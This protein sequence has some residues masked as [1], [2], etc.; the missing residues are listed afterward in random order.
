M[1]P[2]KDPEPWKKSESSLKS[3]FFKFLFL[4]FERTLPSQILFH[5]PESWRLWKVLTLLLIPRCQFHFLK[6]PLGKRWLNRRWTRG[7]KS[8]LE[9]DQFLIDQTTKTKCMV[10][11]AGAED[12]VF[13]LI[14]QGKLHLAW[15][16]LGW[17][18]W[19][20]GKFQMLLGLVRIAQIWHT[21]GRRVILG[22]LS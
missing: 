5:V 16:E 6:S 10:F 13:V 2:F 7:W 22:H 8:Q 18:I 3:Y 1:R 12:V 19:P 17:D 15:I 20:V 21:T 14:T 9:D 4:N 11:L